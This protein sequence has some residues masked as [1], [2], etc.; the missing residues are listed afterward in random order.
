MAGHVDI[1]V[2]FAF[3][4]VVVYTNRYAVGLVLASSR[5][6]L[7]LVLL[8]AVSFWKIWFNGL[9]QRRAVAMLEAAGTTSFTD[10]T[11]ISTMTAS[12]PTPATTATA[13][14]HGDQD[15]PLMQ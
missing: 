12:S 13:G 3:E 9:R 14:R 10:A 11:G 6:I 7:L 2:I 8:C 15:G 1:V 4:L 5:I